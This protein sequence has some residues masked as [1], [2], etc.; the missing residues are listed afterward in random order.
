LKKVIRKRKREAKAL[1][2]EVQLLDS[3]LEFS[4]EQL[5]QVQASRAARQLQQQ[6]A[7]VLPRP[8][9]ASLAPRAFIA[10]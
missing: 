9:Q 2:Q 5:Q 8:E 10:A 4:K 1:A 3:D 7:L 6:V